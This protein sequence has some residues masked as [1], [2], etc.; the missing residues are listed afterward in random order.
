MK[1]CLES[2]ALKR[3]STEREPPQKNA[4]NNSKDGKGHSKTKKTT[5][6][7][8]TAK[9]KTAKTAYKKCAKD[10]KSAPK[11][12]VKRAPKPKKSGHR[13]RATP[14]RHSKTGHSKPTEGFEPPTLRL[15]SACSA[16]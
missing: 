13:T 5:A 10:I 7:T 16:N 8:K 6:K 12:D 3:R 1:K 14:K 9:T 4:K 15:L 11:I 2:A